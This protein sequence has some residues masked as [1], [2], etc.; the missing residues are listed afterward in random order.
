MKTKLSVT[1]VQS[2]ETTIYCILR[3]CSINLS[4]TRC[5]NG[6]SLNHVLLFTLGE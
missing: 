1:G 3:R 6:P 5:G 4:T 2:T